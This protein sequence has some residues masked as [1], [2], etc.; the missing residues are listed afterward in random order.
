MQL[1]R[2]DEANLV[3]YSRL[4]EL[5]ML[6][7]ANHACCPLCLKPLSAAGFLQRLTQ[8]AGRETYDITITEVSMFHIEELRPGV[9]QHRPYNLGWGHHHCNV[10]A[11]GRRHTG[12][13]CTG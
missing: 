10:V 2:A 1:H 6:T 13:R 11:K 12:K 7:S 9:L 3:D 4:R 5:R 8:A